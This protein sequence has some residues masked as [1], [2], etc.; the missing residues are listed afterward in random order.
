[1]RAG[2]RR[3][4]AICLIVAFIILA[5]PASGGASGGD[6]LFCGER[7]E[8]LILKP[9]QLTRPDRDVQGLQTR[10]RELGY[11]HGVANG[12]YGPRTAP[13]VI[14]FKQDHH[15]PA[16]PTLD[17]DTWKA[18]AQTY[19]DTPAAVPIGPAE[20]TV[21]I[22]LQTRQLTV[23]SDGKKFRSFPVA[24]GADDS[25]SPVGEWQVVKKSMW[26]EGFGSHWIELDVPWGTYGIHGTNKPWLI[27]QAISKGCIRML[28]SHVEQVYKLVQPGTEIR[29]TRKMPVFKN[30]PQLK[31][32]MALRSV[33]YLQL[34]LRNA[35]VYR[36]RADGRF[37]DSTELAVQVFERFYRLYPDGEADPRVWNTLYS[38]HLKPDQPVLPFDPARV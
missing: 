16:D 35:G 5:L 1:M 24:I 14:S 2:Y 20:V 25:T 30:P 6:P 4:A 28:N 3:L 37:D 11:Y 38:N 17:E 32:G 23:F 36:D 33:V 21:E 19:D 22:N 9:G 29:I 34:L 18:L 13:A 27:G 26:G 31:K 10:L 15:L 8:Y 12:F 7:E